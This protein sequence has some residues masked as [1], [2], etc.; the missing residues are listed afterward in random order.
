MRSFFSTFVLSLLVISCGGSEV[1]PSKWTAADIEYKL[2][3][4][5]G[6]IPTDIKVDSYAEALTRAEQTCPNTRQQLADIAV[7]GVQVAKD[8]GVKTSVLDILRA[9]PSVSSQSPGLDCA[10]L[11]AALIALMR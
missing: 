6:E 3:V 8:V 11:V 5:A 7:R 1:T 4:V 9:L 10:Q 2:A